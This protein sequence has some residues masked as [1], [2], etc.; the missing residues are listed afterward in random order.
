MMYAQG[1]VQSTLAHNEELELLLRFFDTDYNLAQF[2]M[3]VD[4]GQSGDE[5]DFDE[6]RGRKRGYSEQDYNTEDEEE[7]LDYVPPKKKRNDFDNMNLK[8][9]LRYVKSMKK[10]WWR[11]K[12]KGKGR[13][14][15][16]F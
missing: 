5:G 3:S 11:Q 2:G 10:V 15:K 13:G 16:H 6:D 14:G 8:Q 1:I 4:E 9:K 12:G 7:E